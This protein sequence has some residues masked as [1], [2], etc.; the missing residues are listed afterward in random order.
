[1]GLLSRE[2]YAGS[3][4]VKA[5]V[6]SYRLSPSGLPVA[7]CHFQERAV[8]ENRLFVLGE[9]GLEEYGTEGGKCGSFKTPR[10]PCC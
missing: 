10:A 4:L 1:M 3:G 9:A 7:G 8:E 6:S 2:V 5:N